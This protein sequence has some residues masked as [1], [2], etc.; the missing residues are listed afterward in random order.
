MRR[1]EHVRQGPQLVVGR[2][3]LD[4][5]DIQAGTGQPAL[6]ERR[7][8]RLAVHD[9]SPGGGDQLGRLP[10]AEQAAGAVAEHQVHRDDVALGQQ[11][12]LAGGRPDADL[13]GPLGGA[14]LVP[15][16][17]VHPE[18]RSDPGHLGTDLPQARQAE[19]GAG[20]VDAEGALPRP[21]RAAGT[22]T[23]ASSSVRCSVGTVQRMDMGPTA[24]PPAGRPD[25]T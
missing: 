23:S 25:R 18:G 10:G 11:R 1:G 24:G 14:V 6:P 15:P 2:E 8:Q 9:G 3:R 20:Q 12:L 21:T 7:Y 17:D 4:V 13:R 16:D 22:V 19:R 5:E